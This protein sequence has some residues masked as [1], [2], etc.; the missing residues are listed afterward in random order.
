MAILYVNN[1]AVKTPSVMS[2]GIYDISE[3]DS[4]RD[5]SGKMWKNT[6]CQKRTIELEWW[7]PS[8]A[9]TA[10]ILTLFQSNEY[11]D[12][13]YYD[14]TNSTAMTEKKFYLGDRSIPVKQW[15]TNNKRY[16]KISFSIIE[17]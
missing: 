15:T 6:I 9:D 7:N 13:K 17:Q 10:T 11:F 12:V 2:F 14:P 8:A 5:L 16:E 1:T 4:G 3:P